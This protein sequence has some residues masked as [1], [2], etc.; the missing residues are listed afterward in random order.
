MRR[1]P[2]LSLVLLVAF[3]ATLGGQA[4][5]HAAT[6]LR[7]TPQLTPSAPDGLTRELAAGTINAPTY[8]LLR[9]QSLFHR[10]AVAAKVGA[11]LRT[12]PREA[13]LILRDLFARYGKLTTSQQRE[14]TRILARPTD[15]NADPIGEGYTVAEQ[16][17]VCDTNFCVHYVGSTSDAP[18]ATDANSNGVPDYVDSTLAVADNVWNTEV[19]TMGYRA[20]ESDATSTNDGGNGKLDI[21]LAD[22]GGDG[23][24]GYCTSDDPNATDPNYQ[25]GDVSPYCVVDNDFAKSQFSTG[26]NGLAALKVTLAHEFFHAVQF[27]Y[28]AFADNWVMEGTATWMEDEVYTSI[29]DNRQYLPVSPLESPV[30][31]L[32][33]PMA[34]SNGCHCFWYG[35]WIWYRFLSEKYGT[36]GHQNTGIIK[37]I[38]DK[39]SDTSSNHPDQYSMQAIV[40]TVTPIAAPQPFRNVYGVF[41]AWNR[42]P[43]RH[44]SEGA[45]YKGAPGSGSFVLQS[46]KRTTGYYQIKLKHLTEAYVGLIPGKTLGTGQHVT[47][48]VLGPPIANAPSALVLVH[49]KSGVLAIHVM[50][51]NANGDNAVRVKFGHG[52]VSSVDLVLVNSST[53]YACNR[54]TLLTCA[55]TANHDANTM[56][57]RAFLS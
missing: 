15:G 12:N 56:V 16:T 8:A 23:I 48:Q 19:G 38:W 14:A 40:N 17:P 39:M 21:Y 25:F 57:F 1:L 7:Q 51:L 42:N 3:A 18:A 30:V 55:G 4:S 22:L 36:P 26:A 37:S 45:A 47:V 35:S 31:P 6:S 13:T 2:L 20:P 34:L 44:Y 27:A 41:A 54:G 52:K 11:P 10:G 9:A 5:A 43:K 50:K 46:T 33:S 32:D 53:S 29:N 28:N 24:Y 49:L